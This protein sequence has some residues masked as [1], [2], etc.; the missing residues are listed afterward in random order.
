MIYSIDTSAI[1]HSWVVEHP[2]DV[3]PSVWV[4]LEQL[5]G[6]GALAAPEEVLNELH[7]KDDPALKWAKQRRHMFVPEDPR[8]QATA[9]E[10]LRAHPRLVDERKTGPQADPFVIALAKVRG[11]AVVTQE[12]ATGNPKRP[13]IPD[14]RRALGVQCLTMVE[15]FR[16][17]GWSF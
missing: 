10:I 1:L 7:G 15:L 11:C 2:P 13:H 8:I 3:F 6:A 17:Q 9:K 5:I 14:V 16:G 12:K 4:K